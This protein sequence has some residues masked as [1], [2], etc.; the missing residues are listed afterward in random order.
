MNIEMGSNIYRKN[1]CPIA[2][3]GLY[4]SEKWPVRSWKNEKAFFPKGLFVPGE[5]A[6]RFFVK[7]CSF[8]RQL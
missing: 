4:V 1:I 3:K 8:I 6:V 7:G 2:T 5:R